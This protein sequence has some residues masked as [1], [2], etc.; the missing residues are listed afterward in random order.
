MWSNI[1]DL[2]LL[3]TKITC[4]M[5]RG[6]DLGHLSRCLQCACSLQSL[7]AR[8]VNI[9]SYVPNRQPRK[10]SRSW[11]CTLVITCSWV[12]TVDT[13]QSL[14]SKRATNRDNFTRCSLPGNSINGERGIND[15]RL[16]ALRETPS[17]VP[18]DLRGKEDA[19]RGHFSK[20][21]LFDLSTTFNIFYTLFK[22]LYKI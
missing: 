5:I 3:K 18:F 17:L 10:W 6:D 14:F 15:L 19:G 22:N 21:R 7:S 1:S 2:D 16:S 8:I 4:K 13:S 12:S 9:G 11:S 20:E